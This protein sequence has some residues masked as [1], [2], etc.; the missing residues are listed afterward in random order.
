MTVSITVE[1]YLSLITVLVFFNKLIIL[2]KIHL[3]KLS[4]S[5]ALFKELNHKKLYSYLQT[6]LVL[7]FLNT[8][9]I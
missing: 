3:K 2:L 6:K 7:K 4:I 8:N 9:K 1:L 5:Q